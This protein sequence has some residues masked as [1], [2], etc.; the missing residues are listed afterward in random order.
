MNAQVVFDEEEPL[1]AFEAAFI[2]T[3][4]EHRGVFR[5]PSGADMQEAR[6]V[7]RQYTAQCIGNPLRSAWEPDLS[8]EALGEL[9][10]K[11]FLLF[12]TTKPTA[13]QWHKAHTALFG[14]FLCETCG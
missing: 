10:A 13:A 6:E 7:L 3:V 5:A 4:L 2:R 1:S 11:A 9:R 14:P 8:V 12:D